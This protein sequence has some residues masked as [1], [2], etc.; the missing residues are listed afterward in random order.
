MA[1]RRGGGESSN[2][3][4][5]VTLVFFVLA[6]IGLGVGTYMGYSGKADAEK[7]TK[8]ANDAKT[9]AEKKA[10]EEQAQRLAVV[11]AAGAAQGND[12]QTFNGL[13]TE[14]ASSIQTQLNNLRRLQPK[15]DLATQEIGRAHV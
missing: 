11:V 4:L 5:I 10:R 8:S 13:R 1:S 15:W 9:T 7:A 6:T 2:T 3:G 12:L 14:F